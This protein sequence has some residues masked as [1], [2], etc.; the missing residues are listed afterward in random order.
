MVAEIKE[1]IVISFE[2]AKEMLELTK[3]HFKNTT[4][5]V[6]ITNSKNSYSFNPTSHFKTAPIF[7]NLK[8]YAIVAYDSINKEIAQME[9]P[10]LNAPVRIFD[11]LE[12]AIKWV[13]TIILID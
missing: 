3:L 1:G 10:F 4:P 8:G 13:E 6:Y 12:N 2:N 11:D 9:K 5:F 7:P